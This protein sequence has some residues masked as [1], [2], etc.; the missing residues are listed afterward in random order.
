MQNVDWVQGL[1]LN[2]SYGTTGNDRIGNFPS[3]GTFV[4]NNYNAQSGLTPS[5]LA[6]PDLR[7][8]ST[9]TWD[10]GLSA[11]FLNNR[12]SFNI[13]YYN[14]T[15]DDL[16]LAVP[17][18]PT[19]NNGLNSV[20]QNI[21]EM[22]N[23]GFELTLDGVI[24]DTPG[25]FRWTSNFNVGYNVNEVTS[26]PESANVDEQ[27]RRFVEQIGGSLAN[28]PQRAVQGES[29]NS[30]YVIPYIGVNPQTGDAEWLDANGN[31]TTSP[32][33]ADRRIVG[34]GNPDFVGGF[35]NVFTYKNW[36][37]NTLFNYSF[38]NDVLLTSKEF[39][40]NPVSGFNKSTRLLNVWQQP[41]DQAVTPSPNSP[42]IFTFAQ[43]SSAQIADGSFVRLK[44][45]TLS[46]TLPQSLMDNT[47]ISS[48]R[49]YATGTN[50]ITFKS[51]ELDGFDPEVSNRA[52]GSG[53]V[54]QDFFTVPQASTFTFGVN[55]SF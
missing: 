17:V 25:G 16:I 29:A 45:V 5:T 35:S 36:S 19:F 48:V 38:G 40:E 41:G 23:R 13:E 12:L 11:A 55:V 3:L 54:G 30:W 39:I 15:T 9:T 52:D 34:Q 50:L 26:L 1:K 43:T 2:A 4:G 31:A 28:S 46:Y 6:N 20:T 53:T 7:W 24:F 51:D 18:D 44:N 47:F 33:A 37:L 10:I 32:V 42:T 21:G 27:G 22:E 49:L 14:R 8:E